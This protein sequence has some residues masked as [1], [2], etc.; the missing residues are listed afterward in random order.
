MSWSFGATD[1]GG[2]WAWSKFP[3]ERWPELVQKLTS[4]ER[5]DFQSLKNYRSI[6]Q[7]NS[8]EKE[9][10][11]RLEEIRKDDLPRLTS[12]HLQGIERVWCADHDS[13]MFVL[14][15][16][17]FHTVYRVGKKS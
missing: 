5:M 13:I 17:P 8:L 6:H 12:Y 4:F 1:N 14:W 3:P 16:D 7:L 11:L 10:R 2:E 9:A 15:W